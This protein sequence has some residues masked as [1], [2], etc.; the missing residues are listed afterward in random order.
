MVFCRNALGREGQAH[1]HKEGVEDLNRSNDEAANASE[2]A[3]YHRNDADQ[4]EFPDQAFKPT[5][6]PRAAMVKSDHPF[7]V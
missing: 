2:Q 5:F 7:A 1:D 6:N 3:Q 4:P